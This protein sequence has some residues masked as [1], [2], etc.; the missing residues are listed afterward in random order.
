VL[1]CDGVDQRRWLALSYSSQDKGMVDSY[2]NIWH[3][4]K[5]LQLTS[6]DPVRRGAGIWSDHEHAG[7]V[8]SRY[9]NQAYRK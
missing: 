8:F 7:A 2:G 1:P 9:Y 3:V 6:P 5:T 4:E